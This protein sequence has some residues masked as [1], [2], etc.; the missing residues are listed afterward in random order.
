MWAI[1]L[2]LLGT[3]ALL[4]WLFLL[5]HPARP[6][7]AQPVGEDEPEPPL[8]ETWPAVAVLIPARNEADALP[9]T[10]P[11]LLT[12]DYPGPYHVFVIDDRS[13]D[14]TATVA[15]R[16][17]SEHDA[18]GRLTV[19]KGQPLPEGWV[20][21]VWALQQ[22]VDAAVGPA[23]LDDSARE[24]G[25]KYL[26]LTDADIHHSPHSLRRLVA[27]SERSGWALNSRMARLRCV[28]T[29]ENLLIPPFVFFFNLL[30]PMRQVNDPQ[31][32]IA[33]AAGGCVLLNARALAAAGGFA[34]MKDALIDDCTLARL[35][36]G[37][38]AS[39]HLA[40]SRSDVT[41]LRA[42]DTL[43]SIWKMVRRSAFTEL[44]YSWLRLAG[45]LAG[46]AL[47]FIVPPALVLIGLILLL[48]SLSGV[49][50]LSPVWAVV[51]AL[52][53]GLAWGIMTVL[54]RPMVVHYGRSGLWAVTLPVAGLLYGVMTLDSAW[55]HARGSGVK[56]R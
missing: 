53:G 51:V 10:L 49:V 30:Y 25:P 35:V 32:R 23:P 22:G 28:S 24:G 55:R 14:G 7:D 5:L 12:Q 37:R 46:L 47:T 9:Q 52:K 20:G 41:S 34:A 38:E 36:K 17:A 54:F 27:G 2:S 8:P 18:I 56:W 50:A 15:G 44:K 11:P 26:L 3:A 16:V 42:Y 4:A 6:W 45:A 40:L 29:A 13:E 39:L 43:G 33:G 21:K 1:A 19:L 48:L 31:S